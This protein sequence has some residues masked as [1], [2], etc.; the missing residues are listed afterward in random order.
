[1]PFDLP[2][3]YEGFEREILVE[4][5]KGL[6]DEVV[7]RLTE[8]DALPLI[9]LGNSMSEDERAEIEHRG[10]AKAAPPP[11]PPDREQEI[12]DEADE[13]LNFDDEDPASG[14]QGKTVR[15]EQSL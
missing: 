5:G 13:G 12:G 2:P 15:F 11:V 3:I 1:M 8:L 14:E 10:N 4:L 6:T 9:G 7:E